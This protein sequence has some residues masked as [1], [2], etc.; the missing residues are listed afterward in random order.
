MTLKSN[1]VETYTFGVTRS[2]QKNKC[3]ARSNEIVGTKDSSACHAAEMA[4]CENVTLIEYGLW[5]FKLLKRRPPKPE[6]PKISRRAAESKRCQA[7]PNIF[8]RS[9][10][11]TAEI[12]QLNMV[13]QMAATIEFDF[14]GADGE[15]KANFQVPIL[16]HLLRFLFC[17]VSEA[18]PVEL[19]LKAWSLFCLDDH[20]F[21]Y[22]SYLSSVV[23]LMSLA[24]TLS[25]GKLTRDPES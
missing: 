22:L 12:R 1:G 13:E 5:R 6:E 7:T 8:R 11:P 20:V 14:Y 4:L 23:S 19:S 21:T 16:Q 10:R 17:F 18:I 2:N 15:L 25:S 24:A 9:I 3:S